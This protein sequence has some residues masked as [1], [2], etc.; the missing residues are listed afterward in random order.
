[1][2][3]L[4]ADA[5]SVAWIEA[6]RPG[7]RSL[8]SH[9][10][11]GRLRAEIYDEIVEEILAPVREGRRV[12]AAFYG[13]P[14]VFSYLGHESVRRARGEGFDAN[15][16]PGISAADCLFADLGVDP[17]VGGLQ[18][19]EATDFLVY[20]RSV[21]TTA[22]LVLWQVTAIGERR[23]ITEPNREGLRALTERLLEL[24]PGDHVVSLYEASP[25]P[26]PIADPIVRETALSAL[27]DADVSP[28]ATLYVPPLAPPRADPDV[29]ARL[30]LTAP[31]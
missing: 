30:G 6:L 7:A 22:A 12:C 28:L 8:H 14:G 9:Y 2:Y 11:S 1:M 17:G 3:H 20:R 18:T 4:L 26:Y 24:Y 23:A 29:S 5:A 19:Y 16:L 31:D 15:M 13:H 25:Y 27:G 21:E 10:K